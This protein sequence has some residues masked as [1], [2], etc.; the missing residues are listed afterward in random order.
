MSKVYNYNFSLLEERT[1]PHGS[2]VFLFILSQLSFIHIIH[3]HSFKDK[4]MDEEIKTKKP[5][6]RLARAEPNKLVD[7]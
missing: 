2:T 1:K 7:F 6:D 4:L 3:I 5:R